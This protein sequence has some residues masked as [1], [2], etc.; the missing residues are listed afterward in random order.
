WPRADAVRGQGR[1]ADALAVLEEGLKAF[2]DRTGRL[3]SLRSLV[4]LDDATA[5]VRG[6]LRA[7]SPGIKEAREDAEAAIKAGSEGAGH[8]AAGSD[9][10]NAGQGRS[11]AGG[12]RPADGQAPAGSDELSR[13]R[14]ALARV[15]LQ[16]AEGRGAMRNGP[17][18][19]ESA[20]A[21][22]PLSAREL[23]VMVLVGLQPPSPEEMSQKEALELARKILERK[24]TDQMPLLKAQ[25]QAI[26]GM[27]TQALNTYVEGLRPHLGREQFEGLKYI[28]ENH[29]VQRRPDR[30]RVPQPFQ[31]ERHYV[32]G[33][34][35]FHAQ[36]YAG[37]EKEFARAIGN[38]DQDARYHYFLG[39]ARLQ[40]GKRSAAEDFDEAARLEADGRPARDAVDAALER[41][42]G[43]ARRLIKEARGR[44]R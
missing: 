26:Q 19:R 29:P 7:D 43:E 4:R 1:F 40:Q 23:L 17:L 37:A 27:W 25:A 12:A 5:K 22:R 15:L 20:V 38:F 8:F 33:L 2:P 13:Y 21:G 14:L 24:D 10:R 36:D 11:R 34:G 18:T 28:V 30:L 44:V 35:R 42:Q 16:Q 32:T 31:A 9:A 39:L 6:K 41:V 3:L